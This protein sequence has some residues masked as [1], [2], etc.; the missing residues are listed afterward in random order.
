M[1]KN[2]DQII[3]S[4]EELSVLELSQL[5]KKL[6]EKFEV[7]AAS[8]VSSSNSTNNQQTTNEVKK[9]EKTEYKNIIKVMRADKIK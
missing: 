2:F 4:I 9:E 8:M 7:S 3:K 1:S 5:I 6:E